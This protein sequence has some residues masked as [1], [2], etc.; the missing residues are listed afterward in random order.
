LALMVAATPVLGAATPCDGL[1]AELRELADAD[2][3]T[4]DDTG[5]VE[6]LSK[7]LA[8][9]TVRPVSNDINQ[10]P[11]GRCDG[12]RTWLEEAGF[13]SDIVAELERTVERDD[14]FCYETLALYDER[15]YG[16]FIALTYSE[17]SLHCTNGQVISLD[18][19]KPQLGPTYDG[20]CA[21]SGFSIVRLGDTSFPA[22]T[23]ANVFGAA[24]DY[25]LD[26][27]AGDAKDDKICSLTLRY[28]PQYRVAHWF[29]P[30]GEGDVDPALRKIIEP[31][32]LARA[33]GRETKSMAAAFLDHPRGDSPYDQALGRYPDV[34][35]QSLPYPNGRDYD[36][37]FY[38]P[39]TTSPFYLFLSNFDDDAATPLLIDGHRLLLVFG[40][41]TDRPYPAPGFGVL[42]WKDNDFQP[43]AGGILE[44]YGSDPTIE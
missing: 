44:K 1:R 32:V 14:Q 19:G 22:I 35:I 36:I 18:T 40:P 43:F 7:V 4:T 11:V 29:G 34:P 13:S 27:F 42:E 3:S 23:T 24:L 15:A 10:G 33:A 39:F 5:H 25:R 12:V 37:A 31:I 6:F 8:A 20:D 2:P 21:P 9:R 41:A 16:G 30:K 38:V 28:Q 26:L 17:G